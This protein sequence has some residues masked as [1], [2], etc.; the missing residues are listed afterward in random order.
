MSLQ[1]GQSQNTSQRR[2]NP[3]LTTR[4]V[5]NLFDRS[6]DRPAGESRRAPTPLF[7]KSHAIVGRESQLQLLEQVFHRIHASHTSEVV[8][9]RGPSGVGKSTLVDVFINTLPKTALFARGKF[10]QL[11]FRA[12]FSALVSL[13]EHL[14][15]QALRLDSSDLIRERI[16]SEL[17][18]EI[19]LLGNLIPELAN[20]NGGDSHFNGAKR[21][22]NP[23][24]SNRFKQVFRSFLRCIA[25]EE[26]PVVIFFD[27]FQWAD[28]VS[29]EILESIM[30]D[31]LSQSILIIC[32]Y[33]DHGDST[34]S[35]KNFCFVHDGSQNAREKSQYRITNILVER[36]DADNLNIIISSALG[37]DKKKTESF[38]LL[39]WKKTD[40][41]PFYVLTFLEM[42]QSTGLLSQK[43]DGIWSWDEK[44]I[45]LQTNV[46][47]NLA[48]VM[49][50]KLM[51]L[52][53]HARS[54]LQIASFIG[55]W[56]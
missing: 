37:M 21:C 7:T 13:S 34:E 35:L 27:D 12:P 53:N 54:I 33:R 5:A 32:A 44:Q 10:D 42:L 45:M 49:E 28:Y 40:G 17:G 36:L 50:S 51:R 38:S 11:Q 56:H 31:Y 29:K 52:P 3:L 39:T 43:L 20:L 6:N 16:R 47:D 23:S 55:R 22:H 41:I 8:M 2:N 14:C 1:F 30:T 15:R 46:A 19:S 25:S 48:K 24:S 4:V 18:S 9:I 26:N